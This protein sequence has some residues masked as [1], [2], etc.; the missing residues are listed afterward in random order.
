MISFIDRCV[1]GKS[2]LEEIDDYIDIWHKSDIA[3]SL[4]EFLGFSEEEYSVWL[5]RPDYLDFIINLRKLE[6]GS[7]EE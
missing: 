3:I 4:H 1:A 2:S 5:K 7:F 6:A